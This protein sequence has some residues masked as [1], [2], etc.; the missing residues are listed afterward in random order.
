MWREEVLA[1]RSALAA[2][3]RSLGAPLG[4]YSERS[5]FEKAV[6]YTRESKTPETGSSFT[7]IH[8]SVGTITPSALHYER[9]HAG[10]PT[11]DPA[12][13]RLVIHGMVDR[14]LSLSMADIR[15]LPSITRTLVLECGGN[16]AGEWG[17]RG[18]DVQ[19]SY[20]MVSGSE[21]T[22]VPLSL[23]L[24]EVGVQPAHRG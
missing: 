19:R 20:G 22:G 17:R 14:P 5:P 15:R 2:E 13:H 24:A 18:A 11:I 16:S 23:L 4:P 21:W 7:P 8:D 10:I 3:A 12:A 6:R 1:G 9:H